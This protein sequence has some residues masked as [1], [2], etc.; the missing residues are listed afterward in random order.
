MSKL[1]IGIITADRLDTFKWYK[2]NGISLASDLIVNLQNIDKTIGIKF[3]TV[4]ITEQA[5]KCRNKKEM[6]T[7]LAQVSLQS[8]NV[9]NDT[10]MKLAVDQWNNNRDSK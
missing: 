7:I 5:L 9:I 1:K 2:D 4:Y 3:S 8:E 10:K 6:Q